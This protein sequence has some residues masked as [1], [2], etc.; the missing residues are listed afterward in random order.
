[1]GILSRLISIFKKKEEPK[2]GE[3]KVS[4]LEPQLLYAGAG[5]EQ[6]REMKSKID[7][8]ETWLR[9]EG[10]SRSWF[11][12]EFQ[13][14]S[15]EILKKI[16]E[17]LKKLEKI[18]SSLEKKVEVVTPPKP[19]KE[20]SKEFVVVREPEKIKYEYILT[21]VDIEILKVLKKG[22]LSFTQLLE[23]VRI[24]RQTLSNHLKELCRVGKIDSKRKGK[25]K[26]YYL[27]S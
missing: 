11:K 25:F 3:K 13:D 8:I 1:M 20:P 12:E 6:L 21:P 16:D 17:V 23:K 22:P 27:I 18:E 19:V 7:G 4:L 26:F 24:S 9:Y 15:P 5:L 10:V 2:K 14:E